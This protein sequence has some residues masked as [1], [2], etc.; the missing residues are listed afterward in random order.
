VRVGLL[1]RIDPQKGIDVF[2][3][4]TTLLESHEAEF[5]IGGIG[6]AFPDYEQRVRDRARD[7]GVQILDTES[8]G[9]EFL[10]SLDVVVMPSRWE[11]SPL[12]MF[13]SMALQKA[14]VATNIPGISE[15]LRPPSA[16]I[17]VPPEDAEATADAILRLI[18]DTDLRMA[19]SAAARAASARY[20]QDHMV[21]EAIV[22]LQ[23]ALDAHRWS[24]ARSSRT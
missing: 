18:K 2:L 14:I 24:A 23:Q 12:T 4:A 15:V 19:V 11:G 8:G 1:G 9:L 17:L 10:R 7:L 21:R 3:E 20:S 6:G 13:E 5:V 16:G 22:T